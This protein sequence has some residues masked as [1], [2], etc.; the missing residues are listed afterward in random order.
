MLILFVGL[1]IVTLCMNRRT[2]LQ[3]TVKS[4][5]QKGVVAITGVTK[6]LGK[7]LAKQ[8]IE[9][10]WR[11][12]G[13][14][15]SANAIADLQKEYD[16]DHFFSVVDVTDNSAVKKWAHEVKARLGAP[17]ILI[18]NAGVINDLASLWEIPSIEFNN[19]MTVNV[20]GVF[21]VLQHF[22]PIMLQAKTG[23]IINVSSGGGKK[24]EA[25]F[26]PYCASKFAIEGLTQSLAAELPQ[27]LTVVSIDPGD[28]INTDMLKQI[29]PENAADYPNPDTWAKKT[30]PYLLRISAK[31][32]G[33]SLIVPN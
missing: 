30:V 6:G 8:F 2:D 9:E 7:A 27:G 20:N 28:G 18:N 31:D 24:G 15:T 14:G 16:E 19:V 10:G 33:K 17:N 32:N 3:V 21:N 25:Q 29:Y 1:N 23:L 5:G 11:V 4:T 22:I 13:C 12:A 26:A